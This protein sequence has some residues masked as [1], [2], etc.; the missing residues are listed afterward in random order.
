MINWTLAYRAIFYDRPYKS[1]IF[2][3]D[4]RYD[5][6]DLW[7]KDSPLGK[8]LVIIDTHF[9]HKDLVNY[10][11]CDSLD[12]NK[13]FDILLHGNKVNTINLLT[14]KHYQGLK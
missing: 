3:L 2:L 4:N 14:C 1:E 8:D 10:L 13:S 9:F 5:Q 6:F 12:N 7:Q 11:K